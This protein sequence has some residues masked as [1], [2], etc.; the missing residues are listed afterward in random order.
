MSPILCKDNRRSIRLP[1]YDYSSAGWYFITICVHGRLSLFGN[2]LNGEMQ[3][4]DAGR[5]IDIWWNKIETKFPNIQIGDYCIMPNHFHGMLFISSV[6]AD[7]CVCPDMEG[8]HLGAP[9]RDKMNV[10]LVGADPCVCP[11]M[12]GAH[13]GAPLQDSGASL[14]TIVQWLKT[15][16]TNEYIRAVREQKWSP[17][18]GRLWQRNFYEHVVRNEEELASV[19]DYIAKNPYLWSEDEYNPEGA[20]QFHR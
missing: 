20:K 10:S 8:A 18:I 2:I 19:R 13:L 14:S 4:N 11:D 3:L 9:L 1:G 12:E 6:G 7:P 5:M 17:F 16:T 15:M